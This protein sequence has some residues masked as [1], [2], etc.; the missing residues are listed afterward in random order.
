[1]QIYKDIDNHYIYLGITSTAVSEPILF[2]ANV[3]IFDAKITE[4][5]H[6]AHFSLKEYQKDQAIRPTDLNLVLFSTLIN[7]KD[8]YLAEN[9]VLNVQGEVTLNFM[10]TF[11]E[12]F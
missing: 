8:R 12:L 4:K 2:E 6:E 5:L 7:S 1:L 3:A 9:G 11:N 10:E